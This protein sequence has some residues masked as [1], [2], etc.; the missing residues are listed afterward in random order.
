MLLA[1]A[2]KPP[3]N[4]E[5]S[6]RTEPIGTVASAAAEVTGSHTLTLGGKSAEV[7]YAGLTPTFAG[8]YQ[9][10]FTV[11]SG[12]AAGNQPL[13]LDVNGVATAAGAYITV[14]Q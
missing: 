7:S 4:E 5:T 13:A 3:V 8:L 10:N 2:I 1:F 6:T 11:P 12:L 9:L 14:A